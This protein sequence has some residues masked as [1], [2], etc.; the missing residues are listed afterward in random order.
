VGRIA[1]GSCPY[2]PYQGRASCTGAVERERRWRAV[3]DAGR[4]G[5]P[6]QFTA[7]ADGNHSECGHVSRG[8]RSQLLLGGRSPSLC[9]AS[10]PATRRASWPTGSPGGSSALVLPA[11]G[12]G[13]ERRPG[14][15]AAR[16]Q[17]RTG[18][19][20]AER[21]E[22]LAAHR[23]AFQ[24]AQAVAAGR[25]AASYSLIPRDLR[26]HGQLVPPGL[27]PGRGGGTPERPSAPRYGR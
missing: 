4:F 7:C 11:S 17:G 12:V 19:G 24:A 13:R 21:Q 1:S 6:D 15:A 22:D 5:A 9:C 10:V 18:K 3:P 16:V 20:P 27:G 23:Q 25:T 8:V 14:R 2:A 26:A